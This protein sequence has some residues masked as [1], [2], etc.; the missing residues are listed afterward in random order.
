MGGQRALNRYKFHSKDDKKSPGRAVR[1]FNENLSG[2]LHIV[3]STVAARPV[4]KLVVLTP[5]QANRK[6]STLKFVYALPSSKEEVLN[7][8]KDLDSEENVLIALQRIRDMHNPAIIAD[9]ESRQKA[10]IAFD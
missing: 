4:T 9:P 8:L 7:L 2:P 3:K 10:E 6:S 1:K 5:E